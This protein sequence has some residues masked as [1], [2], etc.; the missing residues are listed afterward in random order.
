MTS[1]GIPVLANRPPPLARLIS[2]RGTGTSHR[3]WRDKQECLF[4]NRRSAF[5][6]VSPFAATD[7]M[8]CYF[9]DD[10]CGCDTGQQVPAS[11]PLFLLI[12]NHTS[13]NF[14]NGS[15]KDGRISTMRGCAHTRLMIPYT[16]ADYFRIQSLLLTQQSFRR[17]FTTL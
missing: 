1:T 8:R 14:E 4:V 12:R 5:A 10:N 3:R 6:A 2:Q 17:R 15:Y 16:L 9:H 11:C 13:V 7:L